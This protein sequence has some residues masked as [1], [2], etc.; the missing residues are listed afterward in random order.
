MKRELTKEEKEITNKNLQH[1]R[2][3]LAAAEASIEYNEAVLEKQKYLREF[4]EKWT[5]YLIKQKDD[6]D[7]KILEAMKLKV[8]QTKEAITL[9]ET[10]LTEGVEVIEN[11]LIK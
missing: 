11:S 7:N 1:T 4:Q 2:D 8:E 10:Q 3:E 6:E 5:S 9:T